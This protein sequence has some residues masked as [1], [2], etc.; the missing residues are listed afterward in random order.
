MN[1][2]KI[3]T[4]MH[5]HTHTQAGGTQLSPTVNETDL[6]SDPDTR[7]MS[8]ASYKYSKVTEEGVWQQDWW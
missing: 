6:M 7:T 3:S 2:I 8:K 5:T 4:T 1:M